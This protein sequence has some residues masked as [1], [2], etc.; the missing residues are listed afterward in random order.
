[1]LRCTALVQ[2]TQTPVT[3]QSMGLMAMAVPKPQVATSRSGTW[4]KEHAMVGEPTVKPRVA[5]PGGQG[6]HFAM[7]GM[8][9][10]LLLKAEA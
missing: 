6:V 5:E 4:H 8:P 3:L 2:G 1:M 9:S 7:M 10:V